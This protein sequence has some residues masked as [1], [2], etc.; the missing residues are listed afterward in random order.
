MLR[1]YAGS[2]P[3]CGRNESRRC[4]RP[5]GRNP[6]RSKI[7]LLPGSACAGIKRSYRQIIREQR[8]K[9]RHSIFCES[10]L[11]CLFQ[12]LFMLQRDH[13]SLRIQLCSIYLFLG[14]LCGVFYWKMTGFFAGINHS[15][16]I[17]DAE[18]EIVP[19]IFTIF[20]F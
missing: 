13:L 7:N 10:R 9:Q 20:C 6:L 2:C 3:P 12:L 14:F 11:F 18:T 16:N 5:H 8:Q 19:F 1:K 17:P 4:N 15:P